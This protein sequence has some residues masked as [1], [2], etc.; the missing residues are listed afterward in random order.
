MTV[1]SF[2]ANSTVTV[3]ELFGLM[4]NN[5]GAG[6]NITLTTPTAAL[7]VAALPDVAIGDSF[8]CNVHTIA[9]RTITWAAGAGVTIDTTGPTPYAA[10]TSNIATFLVTNVAT[11]AVTLYR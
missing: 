5:V 7:I 1:T 9:L 2:T 8:Y 3:A 11:P 10:S 4:I 6:A